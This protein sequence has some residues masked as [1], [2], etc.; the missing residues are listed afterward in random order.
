MTKALAAISLS[1]LLL[2]ACGKKEEAAPQTAPARADRAPPPALALFDDPS[3]QQEGALKQAAG[4]LLQREASI[5]PRQA[6]N[7]LSGS[8]ERT[9]V[10]QICLLLALAG[11]NELSA[12]VKEAALREASASPVVAAGVALRPGLLRGRSFGELISYLGQLKAQPAWLRAR[13][14][15][16]WSKENGALSEAQVRNA[17]ELLRSPKLSPLSLSYVFHLLAAH[18]RATF[19]QEA[20][21]YCHPAVTGD[22]RIRCWRLL[23]A[24]ADTPLSGNAVSLLSY[25][26]PDRRGDSWLVFTRGFPDLSERL[27]KLYSPEAR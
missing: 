25:H 7:C 14:L 22:A 11:K 3:A 17:A 18:D 4:V 27:A 12:T 8:E 5:S 9:A 10:R 16:D 26:Y 2:F 23:A 6:E 20:S 24:L 19:R 21:A 13:L 15:M 1:A